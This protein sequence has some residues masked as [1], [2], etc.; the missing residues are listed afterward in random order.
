MDFGDGKILDVWME[1]GNYPED[2][3]IR[4]CLYTEKDQRYGK[5]LN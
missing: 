2:K 4:I 5:C 1:I 3:N